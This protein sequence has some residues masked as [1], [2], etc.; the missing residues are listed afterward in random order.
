[1]LTLLVLSMAQLSCVSTTDSN[2]V[3]NRDL[4]YLQRYFSNSACGTQNRTCVDPKGSGLVCDRRHCMYFD[5]LTFPRGA[6]HIAVLEDETVSISVR[7]DELVCA[8]TPIPDG[9]GD[10]R[11]TWNLVPAP[12]EVLESEFRSVVGVFFNDYSNYINYY[13]FTVDCLVPLVTQL[14]NLGVVEVNSHL[15]VNEMQPYQLVAMVQNTWR[16][17]VDWNTNL[18]RRTNAFFNTALKMCAHGDFP[19]VALYREHAPAVETGIPGIPGDFERDLLKFNSASFGMPY[20]WEEL[21]SASSSGVTQVMQRFA[22]FMHSK[23]RACQRETVKP[24]VA[25]I[26]REHRRFPRCARTC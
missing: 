1:V 20:V 4:G 2:S 18:F 22:A 8:E 16:G 25:L 5:Q 14:F 19:T 6:A 26:H 23:A 9:L 24:R 7:S 10:L 12:V 15:Q 3:P 21:R 17:S 13:H 11:R